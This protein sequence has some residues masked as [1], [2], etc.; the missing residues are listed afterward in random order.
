MDQGYHRDEVHRAIA[1]ATRHGIIHKNGTRLSLRDDRREIVRQLLLL[2]LVSIN[3]REVQPGNAFTAAN[4][5]V[6]GHGAFFG[7]EMD[8]LANV[9]IANAGELRDEI[10][11][12]QT[13]AADIRALSQQGFTMMR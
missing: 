3:G 7:L 10:S 2:D 13:F 4:V 12:S 9:A 8:E 1:H 11:H 5:L 6:S